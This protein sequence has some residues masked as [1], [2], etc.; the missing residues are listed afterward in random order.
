MSERGPV[1]GGKGLLRGRFSGEVHPALDRIN[2]S[3]PVDIRLWREDVDGSIAHAQMLAA[4]RIL[5]AAAVRRIVAGL[6]KVRRELEAGTFV[7]KPS[8]EDVHMAVERRLTELVGPDGGRVHTGRSRNDQ[9]ASDVRLFLHRLP[10]QVTPALRGVQRA[11]VRL[12]RRDGDAI[13]PAYTHLQRGQPVLLGHHLLA[14]V[15]MLDRDERRLAA[16]CRDFPWPLGAGAA[17]G[18]AYPVDRVRTARALGGRGAEPSRNSLDSVSSRDQLTQWVAGAAQAAVTLSRLGEDLVLWT[19]REFGFARLGDA[20]STGSSIMPQKRNPDGAEL[21]RGKTARVI[22]ALNTLLTLQKGLP[23]GYNKDL[24]EDKAAFFDA[25]DTLLAMLAVAEAMLGDLRFDRA[26][27]RAAVDDPTGFLLAT[28][29]A[30][31]LAKR[32]VPFREAH[33]AVGALVQAA[34]ERGVALEALPLDVFRQAHPRYDRTVYRALTPEAAVAA[35]G[36]IG[37]TAPK[38]VAKELARWEA[39]LG[40][41]RR[42]RRARKR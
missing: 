13:L 2:R 18:A 40:L 31:W 23:L 32:G 8:D 4:R 15:E 21:L 12:A 20:V 6:K 39:T 35:R 7:V 10:D 5:P 38:N 17:T 27:M 30:D 3:L 1:R 16:A 41:A 11:L 19:T 25:L 34:E 26:R 28:E 33:R 22:G 37:G 42:A 14:Y 9:V 29:A 36:A 24:Q